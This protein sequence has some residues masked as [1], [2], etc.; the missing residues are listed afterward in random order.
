MAITESHIPRAGLQFCVSLCSSLFVQVLLAGFLIMMPLRMQVRTIAPRYAVVSITSPKLPTF[1]Q[2]PKI[3]G[4][5][6]FLSTYAPKPP[7]R[8]SATQEP[9]QA[10]IEANSLSLFSNSEALLNSGVSV[11]LT[12]PAIQPPIQ[13]Q[14]GSFFESDPD[15]RGSIGPG[16]RK[17]QRRASASGFDGSGEPMTMPV[18]IISKPTPIYSDEGLRLRIQGEVVVYVEFR[19]DGTVRVIRIDRGL[20]HG[21]DEA[22]ITAVEEL[23]FKPA[24]V[25]GRAIDFEGRAHVE[26]ILIPTTSTD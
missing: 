2:L 12:P 18:R 23:R 8:N 26:F 11:A 5:R 3:L 15:L 22:A 24:S 14:V 7:K 16:L 21:L 4:R 19:A 17:R 9:Q 13:I 25:N 20:G 10:A 1:R 6:V